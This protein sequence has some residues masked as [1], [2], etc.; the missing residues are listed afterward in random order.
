MPSS[1]GGSRWFESSTAHHF[2]IPMPFVKGNLPFFT[3][4]NLSQFPFLK[5]AIFTREGG[6]S[7][8]AY[9]SLNLSYTVGDIAEN[10]SKNLEKV[11]NYFKARWLVW[12]H[13]VHDKKVLVIKNERPISSYTG[14]DA[15]VTNQ[16]SIA[17]LVKLADCQGILLCDPKKKVIAAIHCGWRGNVVNVIGET[18]KT[19]QREFGSEPKNI[20]AG[21]S[22]S[23]GPCCAE[24][25]DYQTLLPKTFWRYKIKDNYFDWWAISCMQLQEAGI[26]EHQIE[27]ARICTVCDKRFFSYRRDGKRTG[28][29]GAVIMLKGEEGDCR[30]R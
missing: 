12:T 9:A 20:W 24:F 13:Q 22:P 23:L 15:L 29:F 27:V 6:Y 16:P 2:F 30:N 19:M 14:F 26:P 3:F 8:E 21:I 4:T 28:R 10:V 1:H 17:L 5:H 18:V 11:K 25:R 7:Q